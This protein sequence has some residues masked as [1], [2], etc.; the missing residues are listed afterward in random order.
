MAAT[1]DTDQWIQTDLQQR[2]YYKEIWIQGRS[3]EANWVTNFTLLYSDDAANW[4]TYTNAVGSTV[5]SK[6]IVLFIKNSL[7]N[8]LILDG[9]LALDMDVD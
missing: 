7:N 2:Y 6:T 3:D 4:T 8:S 9:R 1:D 5:R